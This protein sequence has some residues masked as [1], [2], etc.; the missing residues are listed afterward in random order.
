[1]HF[2]VCGDK[3]AFVQELG[4]TIQSE[5]VEKECKPAA[6]AVLASHQPVHGCSMHSGRQN[7]LIKT[8]CTSAVCS[9][10]NGLVKPFG[11]RLCGLCGM[12]PEVV[13]TMYM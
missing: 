13:N 12:R 5:G 8:T 3:S 11:S 10:Q 9:C 6:E 7:D 1:M 4:E 2:V